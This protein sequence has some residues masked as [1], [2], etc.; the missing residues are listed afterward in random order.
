MAAGVASAINAHDLA[1]IVGPRLHWV[2]VVARDESRKDL[3]EFRSV[4]S[5]DNEVLQFLLVEYERF[6]AGVRRDDLIRLGGHLD[7]C[8]GRSDFELEWHGDAGGSRYLD[9]LLHGLLETG[10]FYRDGIGTDRH[11]RKRIVSI[12]IGNALSNLPRCV[13]F[14]QDIGIGHNRSGRIVN[15]P[16]DRAVN[17]LRAQQS[18]TKKS[19]AAQYDQK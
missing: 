13:A 9:A 10:R 8:R 6:L 5:Y 17:R 11:G 2:R 18:S 7:L 14:E 12:G 19:H 3:D 4:R 15:R 16:R 1:V